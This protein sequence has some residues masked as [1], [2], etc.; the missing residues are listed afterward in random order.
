[1]RSRPGSPRGSGR[2]LRRD[3]SRAPVRTQPGVPRAW[4]PAR[5]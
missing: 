5:G 3:A 4:F 2:I 1:L